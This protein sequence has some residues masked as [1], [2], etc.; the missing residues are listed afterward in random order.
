MKIKRK[1]KPCPFCGAKEEY[2]ELQFRPPIVVIC[3]FVQCQKC[4]ASG[5]IARHSHLIG[6]EDLETKAINFWN[7][8][9]NDG[10]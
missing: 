9:K 3:A 8:R 7:K 10:E 6:N 4:N 1:L 2:L 5:G